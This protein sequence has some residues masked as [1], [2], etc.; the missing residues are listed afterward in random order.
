MDTNPVTELD[1]YRDKMFEIFPTLEVLDGLDKDGN[2]VYSDEGE[3]EPEQDAEEGEEGIDDDDEEGEAFD[4]ED[5]DD[6]D[7]ED[8]YGDEEDES[9]EGLGKRG[10]EPGNHQGQPQKR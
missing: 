2:D 7:G 5:Y 4:D 1:G 3:E 9:E 6:E 8:D 10:G